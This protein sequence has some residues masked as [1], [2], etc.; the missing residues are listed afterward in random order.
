MR[1]SYHRNHKAS[2]VQPIYGGTDSGVHSGE[3]Q[4]DK[5][6]QDHIDMQA[7]PASGGGYQGKG[8]GDVCI[9]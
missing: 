4:R 9:R 7:E 8:K 5:D 6:S 2:E 3:A 1:Q